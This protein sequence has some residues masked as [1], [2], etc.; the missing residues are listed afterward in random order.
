M[1]PSGPLP[2]APVRGGCYS[3]RHSADTQTAR[4]SAENQF[5]SRVIPYP[6]PHAGTPGRSTCRQGG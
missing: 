1:P 5:T 4:L 2:E 3:L 6:S